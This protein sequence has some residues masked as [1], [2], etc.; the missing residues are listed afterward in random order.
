MESDS[1]ADSDSDD[2]ERKRRN[3]AQSKDK[4]LFRAGDTSTA[5]GQQHLD[6]NKPLPPADTTASSFFDI[7]PV[8][9]KDDVTVAKDQT[10]DR[11]LGVQQGA[12]ELHQE[13]INNSQQGSGTDNETAVVDGITTVLETVSEVDHYH[14]PRGREKSWESSVLG[15]ASGISTSTY[16]SS[17]YQSTAS[18]SIRPDPADSGYGNRGPSTAPTS[19]Q[20]GPNY[21]VS[22]ATHGSKIIYHL[23]SMQL[24]FSL[25]SAKINF[26]SRNFMMIP[27]VVS[28][29][30]KGRRKG[31]QREP[32]TQPEVIWI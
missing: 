15:F 22:S 5:H 1:D 28:L 29:I 12:E 2:G 20:S 32:T 6:D 7:L 14:E 4:T 3:K 16:V 24:R 23:R 13:R 10:R 27:A 9:K 30:T 8:E 11:D 17:Y 25:Y 19:L 18:R 21:Q 26:R 31:S